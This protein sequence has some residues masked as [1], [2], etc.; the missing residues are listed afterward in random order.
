MSGSQQNPTE[1]WYRAKREE[2]VRTQLVARGIHD[3]SVLR[4]MQEVPRQRFVPE[5]IRNEAYDDSPLVIGYHQTISQPFIVAYMLEQLHLNSTER[6]LEIGLG[7]G[8]QAA[9]LSR[10]VHEVYAL[11][12]IPELAK[13]ASQTLR[14]LG[15][16]NVHTDCRNGWEGWREHAPFDAIIVAAAAERL[17]ETLLDQLAEGG[18]MILPIGDSRTSQV[19]RFLQKKAGSVIEQ[20]GIAVM[21]V[22]LIDPR[23]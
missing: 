12:I 19:L 4:A 3:P 23:E 16:A 1:A 2:M 6:V 14:E 17:P 18:R 15:F 7:S 20:T 9:V 13:L 8:Y 10:I 22:P 5:M 11:E 21:F